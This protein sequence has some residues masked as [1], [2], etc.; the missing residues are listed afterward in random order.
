MTGYPEQGTATAGTTY[1]C[2]MRTL[3]SFGSAALFY[4]HWSSDP[5]GDNCA[6]DSSFPANWQGA[7]VLSSDDEIVAMVQ[8]LNISFGGWAPGDTP[9]GRAVGAYAGVGSPGYEI[10]FPVYKNEHN[11]EMTTFY[12]Q[13]AGG[14]DATITAVF[15]PCAD[16]GQGANC[17]GYPNVYTYTTST[18]VPQ[19]EMFILDATMARDAGSSP[20]PA[21]TN[22]MG[23][24]TITSDQPIAAVAFEHSKDASPAM[25]VKASTG[26]T[27]SDYD[28]VFYAPS[29][30]YQYPAGTGATTANAAK[31]SALVVHNAD[32]VNV[33]GVVSYT[34]AQRNADP[35]HADVGT[36]YTQTFSSLP[37]G[38]SVFFMF[39]DG[40]NPA[41]G[42]QP[43]DLLAATIQTSG[44]GDIVAVVYE[45][46]DY[47]LGGDKDYIVTGAIPD[48]AKANSLSFP[49]HKMQ[50][51]GKFHGATVQNVGIASTYFTA[52]LSVVGK[53][54]SPVPGVA[55]G[56]EVTF[57]TTSTVPAGG[58]VVYYMVCKDYEGLFVD[59]VTGDDADLA[60]LCTGA[61]S[62]TGGVNTAMVIEADQP[63]VGITN[64]E[65]LWYVNPASAGDGYGEDASSFE[66]FPLD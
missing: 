35:M 31:W 5:A 4:P 52:T 6:N 23:G 19:N 21:G 29:I 42:T 37:P 47:G 13:S 48:S 49:T 7:A 43:R 12:I 1:D 41:S 18:P 22:S 27:P 3:D 2:G 28:D 53:A 14:G 10:R 24:L 55:G 17:L 40:L 65:L 61:G 30:K 38:E 54:G 66:A 39:H 62:P 8:T 15:K 63:I 11:N 36:V 20:M 26:F 58:A 16:N 44:G 9:Y 50:Y 57:V 46:A 56:D 33:S 51:N 25:Y 45:E 32:S 34:L 59:M 60:D 64:E